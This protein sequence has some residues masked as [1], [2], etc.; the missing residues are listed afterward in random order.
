MSESVVRHYLKKLHTPVVFALGLF[1]GVAFI[2][3]A[4]QSASAATFTVTN[5]NADGLGSL[6]QAIVDAN[7]APDHDTI[8]FN[9]PGAG[10]HTINYVREN[11]S[12]NPDE[13]GG[14]PTIVNPVTIDACT[15]PGSDCSI[16]SLN[17]MIELR[18]DYTGPS[19]S[20]TGLGAD[21]AGISISSTSDV[22]IRGL[23][24]NRATTYSTL[25]P[26][27]SIYVER[28]DNA[29][30]VL[31]SS[32]VTIESNILGTDNDGTP[33]IGATTS[34]VSAVLINRSANVTVR[35]NIMGNYPNGV[36][37]EGSDP[38]AITSDTL[39]ESNIIGTNNAGS[40]E[41]GGVGA[42]S[43][44]VA[45]GASVHD[46][47]IRGNII[48]NHNTGIS[49]TTFRSTPLPQL[50]SS[51]TI[52][53]GNRIGVTPDGSPLGNSIGIQAGYCASGVQI[54]GLNAGEANEIT[55]NT[56]AGIT[57]NDASTCSL[58]TKDYTI[59]GNLIRDNDGAGVVVS[60]NRNPTA[61]TI[62]RNSIYNNGGLGIDLSLTVFLGDGVTENGPA[63]ELREGPNN[64]VNYPIITSV[65]H[66]SAIITGTYAGLA[67]QTY[68][69]DFYAND[70]ADPSGHGQGQI[71]IG[72]EA[73]TTDGD[74]N[75][76]FHFT[77]DTNLADGQFVSATATDQDG[78]T[79]E[80]SAYVIV[81]AT[82]SASTNPIN[83]DPNDSLAET[84]SNLP[85]IFSA[86][87][88]ATTLGAALLIRQLRQ[89]HAS[90][91]T[92]T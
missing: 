31:N 13:I 20:P 76:F 46:T 16:D 22:V 77:F 71:W 75:A 40:T 2:M 70:A 30:G 59:I 69:L 72:S 12:A 88:A 21:Q 8:N 1:A 87:A 54:G 11:I 48:A 33:G 82:P 61:M 43:R 10:P 74:G 65:E 92:L 47:T 34:S 19:S 58:G 3:S 18:G 35:G 25:P 5:T 23:M 32:D 27:L 64:L 63:N 26:P 4:T 79:S 86:A 60:G 55:N 38:P 15:Q 62:R 57:I 24:I 80:F 29:V 78:S 53:T 51:E 17:L 89:T 52:I 81:P 6:Y 14:L 42:I 39:V 91:K 84:G 73:V 85:L 56:S 9:I 67:N 45:V 49:V 68:I 41:I 36:N 66:G 28:P 7:A 44:G 83:N 50:Y 90:Y 37:I